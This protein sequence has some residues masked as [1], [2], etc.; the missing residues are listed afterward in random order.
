[1]VTQR[2]NVPSLSTANMSSDSSKVTFT[3]HLF[4]LWG[5]GATAQERQR[6]LTCISCRKC[7]YQGKQLLSGPIRDEYV[8]HVILT[9]AAPELLCTGASEGEVFVARV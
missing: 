9:K 3:L 4:S 5:F 8:N 1:M 7:R 6:C 2:G